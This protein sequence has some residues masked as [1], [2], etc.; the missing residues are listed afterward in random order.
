MFKSPTKVLINYVLQEDVNLP[1]EI[2]PSL[3][4]RMQVS[5]MISQIPDIQKLWFFQMILIVQIFSTGLQRPLEELHSVESFYQSVQKL[6]CLTWSS[7]G[8]S[9]FFILLSQKLETFLLPRCVECVIVLFRLFVSYLP[10]PEL[11]S[12]D[13]AFTEAHLLPLTPIGDL[14]NLNW[15]PKRLSPERL[16][17]TSI[18]SFHVLCFFCADVLLTACESRS[19]NEARH[20]HAVTFTSRE[21]KET[22]FLVWSKETGSP[23]GVEEKGRALFILHP[24]TVISWGSTVSDRQGGK[25][26]FWMS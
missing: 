10:C 26:S 19:E 15:F 20:P 12:G 16:I 14:L 4:E 25:E 5:Y 24:F 21:W 22:S 9:S 11:S 23:Q 17:T 2:I 8:F 6:P 3:E 13:G 1:I 7:G 18:K